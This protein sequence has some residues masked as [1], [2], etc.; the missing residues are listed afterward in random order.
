MPCLICKRD[1]PP[2]VG[3]KK[4]KIRK[5]CSPECL[6]KYRSINSM[7]FMGTKPTTPKETRQ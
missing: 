7:M 3:K 2:L 4:G 1:C 5:T 6:K